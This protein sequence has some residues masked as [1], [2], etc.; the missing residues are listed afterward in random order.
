M[1]TCHSVAIHTEAV[2]SFTQLVS[3]F[4]EDEQVQQQSRPFS[5]AARSSQIDRE[6]PA[7]PPPRVLLS[8]EWKPH[9]V[10]GCR[11]VNHEGALERVRSGSVQSP[12]LAGND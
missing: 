10:I 4:R 7:G 8:K 11:W 5:L 6:T 9:K 3:G 2:V 1:S 12:G